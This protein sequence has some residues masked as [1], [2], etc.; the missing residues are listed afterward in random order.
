MARDSGPREGDLITRDEAERLQKALQK[1]MDHGLSEAMASRFSRF[2]FSNRI[3]KERIES[4]T[5]V[6][7]AES[8]FIDA[9]EENQCARER[10]KRVL[11]RSANEAKAREFDER[12][13]IREREIRLAQL[14]REYEEYRYDGQSADS[15]HRQVEKQVEAAKRKAQADAA[16]KV[17]HAQEQVEIKRE[18]YRQRD[19]MK[20]EII[21]DGKGDLTEEQRRELENIDDIYQKLI[22]EI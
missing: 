8:V 2:K 7:R 21:S 18:I 9:M 10:M 15:Q 1:A 11:A 22:D 19:R 4:A 6:I 20:A 14:D 16:V 5:E 13:A 17:A 3:L 12:I